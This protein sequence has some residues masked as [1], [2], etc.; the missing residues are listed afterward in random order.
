[1]IFYL[2]PF[3]DNL[4]QIFKLLQVIWSM[5]LL[6]SLNFYKLYSLNNKSSINSET[7]AK[8]QNL[9]FFMPQILQ[10]VNLMIYFN[11]EFK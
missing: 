11:K 1:M 6:Q 2:D 7:A 3:F 4:I 9:F 5:L 8:F 10:E